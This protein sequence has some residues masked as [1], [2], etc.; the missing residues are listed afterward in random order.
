MFLGREEELA[1]L[2][3]RYRS[4]KFEYFVLY[5]RQRVGK[6]ELIN[7]FCKD[8]A[9]IS[10]SALNATGKTNL[11]AFSRAFWKSGLKTDGSIGTDAKMKNAEKPSV[12]AGF[13]EIFWEIGQIS[14]KKRVILVIDSVQ[15]LARAE[16]QI[17]IKL[18]NAIDRSWKKGKLFLIICGSPVGYME[19]ELLGEKSSLSG[20]WTVQMQVLPLTYR[21][22]AAF[23]PGLDSE[24]Q[25]LL[26]GITGGIPYYINIINDNR[27]ADG[28]RHA[29]RTTGNRPSVQMVEHLDEAIFRTLFT[30]TGALFEEP[31]NLLRQELREPA[32]YNSVIGAIAGGAVRANEIAR[33]AGIESAVC[34]KYLRILLELGIL[35]KETPAAQ[36]GSKKIA[37]SVRDPFFYFWYRFVWPNQSEICA[38]S[39]Q[40]DY[41]WTVKAHLAL[42]LEPIFEQ[43]CRQYLMHYAK[44]LPVAL[45]DVGSWWGT[46]AD[47]GESVRID[48]VGTPAARD[49]YLVASCSC[50]DDL[51]DLADLQRLVNDA[52]QFGKGSRYHYFLFSKA[53]FT[54]E[55]QNCQNAAVTLLTLDDLYRMP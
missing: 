32:V 38:A 40:R 45:A 29:E 20:S 9:A 11:E 12:Y 10:F 4:G 3:K 23:F 26:Y 39:F 47:T 43:M 42:W 52:K 13:E 46:K 50:S 55:L 31:E 34:A 16:K 33:Q 51:V 30:R 53:G 14:E 44:R 54:P 22:T 35:H 37:Y 24:Y 48:L 7:E 41:D 27:N 8:K 18:Q 28:D 6:T 15:N 49:E 1:E 21:E 36:S 2:E 17:L 19:R 25:A 5:G